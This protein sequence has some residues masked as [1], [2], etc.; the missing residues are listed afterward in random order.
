MAH[1]LPVKTNNLSSNDPARQ[2]SR[3]CAMVHGDA[4]G[5]EGLLEDH[6]TI[7]EQADE[8]IKMAHR[9]SIDIMQD[10]QR[11]I[12]RLDL[13]Q[14][15]LDPAVA[16]PEIT[17]QDIP[18]DAG[19]SAVPQMIDRDAI[20]RTVQPPLAAIGPE[21]ALWVRQ[22]TDLALRTID[23]VPDEIDVAPVPEW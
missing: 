19:V 2:H 21:Q 22:V 14:R 17:G 12:G 16:I 20:E 8:P 4:A 18:H 23:L 11:P 6:A 13:L 7:L 9:T 5:W 10:Y 3:C 15:R 1:R